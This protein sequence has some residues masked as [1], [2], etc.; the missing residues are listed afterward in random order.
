MLKYA[1]IY[2]LTLLVLFSAAALYWKVRRIETK[3]LIRL[4]TLTLC[5][6]VPLTLVGVAM[7]ILFISVIFVVFSE[8]FVR[9]LIVKGRPHNVKKV[10][11][12]VSVGLIFGLVET[13]NWIFVDKAAVALAQSGLSGSALIAA[14]VA[15]ILTEFLAGVVIHGTLTGILFAAQGPD[16]NR[17]RLAL[18]VA[19][20][21]AI[22]MILNGLIFA[23][24]R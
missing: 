11:V 8:E 2:I 20:T 12:A 9:Y 14:D 13:N 3:Y 10:D 5:L 4:L 21:F 24:V 15:Y 22:H 23:G 16:N 17:E 6:V 19:G 7:G 18:G 1:I